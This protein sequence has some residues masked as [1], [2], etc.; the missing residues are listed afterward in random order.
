MDSPKAKEIDDK[1]KETGDKIRKLKADK[2]SKEDIDREVKQLL[3]L[4]TEFKNVTG[5]EWKPEAGQPAA[6][7]APVSLK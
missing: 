6:R 5:T 1:I 3:E 4:K 7:P 2:A